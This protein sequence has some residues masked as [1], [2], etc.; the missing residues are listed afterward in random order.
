VNSTI[1]GE[2]MGDILYG[3]GL[4]LIVLCV[5]GTIY[6]IVEIR[7]NFYGE[8]QIYYISALIAGSLLTISWGLVLIVLG[9]MEKTLTRIHDKIVFI[10][11]LIDK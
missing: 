3:A 9:V 10:S 8:K 5:I 11:R 4:I 6:G 2:K 1:G 7:D